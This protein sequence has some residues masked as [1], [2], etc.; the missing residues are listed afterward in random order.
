MLML[1]I[2][3]RITSNKEVSNES[4]KMAFESAIQEVEV[5]ELVEIH[6]RKHTYHGDSISTRRGHGVDVH[7]I[8]MIRQHA[9]LTNINTDGTVVYVNISGGFMLII[10]VVKT[11]PAS[12]KDFK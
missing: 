6:N 2:N 12:Q 4:R 3:I 1:K 5:I 9:L 8:F 7:Q 10:T 11:V